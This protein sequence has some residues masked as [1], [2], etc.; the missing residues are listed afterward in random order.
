MPI[1][2]LVRGR[3]Y[4]PGKPPEGARQRLRASEPTLSRADGNRKFRHSSGGAAWTGRASQ[5]LRAS[6][7]TL[8]PAAATECLRETPGGRAGFPS[9]P[10]LAAI[11]EIPLTRPNVFAYVSRN[12]RVT[13]NT[14]NSSH[15]ALLHRN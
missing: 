4:E 2:G 5:R 11:Q 8:S 1:F 12:Y 10:Q 13:V 15:A 9:R 7:P 14:Q 6:E 3:C